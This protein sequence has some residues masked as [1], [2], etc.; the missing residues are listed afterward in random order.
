M[1]HVSVSGSR[2]WSHP[3]DHGHAGLVYLDPLDQR[4]DDRLTGCP[5]RCSESWLDWCGEL[6]QAPDHEPELGLQGRVVA[7][8][9]H[10]CLRG[11][12]PFA[13]AP[14]SRGELVLL[15]EPVSVAVAPSAQPLAQLP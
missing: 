4:A 15:D 5:I 8:L 10:L 6:F 1:F 11:G 3:E 14:Q 13:Q 2:A 9:L 12:D 7:L